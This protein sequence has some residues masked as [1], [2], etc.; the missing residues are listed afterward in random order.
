MKDSKEKRLSPLF[1]QFDGRGALRTAKTIVDE[2][3][4]R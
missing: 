4:K 1:T 3:S 2:V